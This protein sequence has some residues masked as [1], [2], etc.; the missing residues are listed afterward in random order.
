M[1]VIILCEEKKIECRLVQ[2]GSWSFIYYVQHTISRARRKQRKIVE[3]TTYRV[4][5]TLINNAY[6]LTNQCTLEKYHQLA[7]SLSPF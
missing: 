6:N 5:L 3:V 7:L 4:T 2:K 1:V